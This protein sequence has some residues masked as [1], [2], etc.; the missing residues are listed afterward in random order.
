MNKKLVA[1]RLSFQAFYML[2][3]GAS[4]S[5][6]D[7]D[8]LC[9]ACDRALPPGYRY[10]EREL[11][12]L[13]TEA[14]K[15]VLQQNKSRE[16]Q[17]KMTRYTGNTEDASAPI[18][19]AN[20]WKKGTAI[21]GTVLRMFHTKTGICYTIKLDKPITAD[22][23]DIYPAQEGKVSLDQVSVGLKGFHMA[24]G[25][26]GLGDLAYGDKIEATCT[27]A[28]DTGKENEMVNFRVIVDRA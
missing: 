11:E 6:R 23:K 16:E 21:R 10:S 4:F 27:G 2:R 12:Q 19:A 9:A 13:E 17:E 15:N 14:Y 5:E 1:L 8:L 24:I 28:T 22:G 26:A 3:R 20:Y 25:A 18:L 7:Y